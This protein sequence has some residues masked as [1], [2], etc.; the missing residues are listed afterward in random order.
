MTAQRMLEI[1]K[2]NPQ[3]YLV[4]DVKD[5]KNLTEIIS[6]L[7]E[8]CGWDESVLDRFIIQLYTGRE[9]TAIQ[10]IYPF[11]DSQFVFTTYKWGI[12]EHEAAQICNEENVSVIAVPGGQMSDED[13]ALMRDLGFTVYE[14]TINRVDKAQNELQRGIAGF[15]TDY[16]SPQDLAG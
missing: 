2:E 9:K 11:E 3:M 12:W 14:F 1:M 13:A 8:L 4:T 10:K 15:Y 7:A 6:Q 5:D 16:L